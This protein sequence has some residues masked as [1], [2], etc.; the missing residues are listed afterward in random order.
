[1]ELMLSQRQDGG[2]QQAGPVGIQYRIQKMLFG[3]KIAKVQ[4]LGPKWM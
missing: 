4:E 2:V 3:T 1:M